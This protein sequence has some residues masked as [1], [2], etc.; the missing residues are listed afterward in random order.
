MAWNAEGGGEG[1][2]HAAEP[3][4][5]YRRVFTRNV[6]EAADAV[7]R[8]FC[9]HR[10]APAGTVESGF[11]ARH[12][13]AALDGFSI[14]YVAYGGTVTID[15]GCLDRFFLLQVPCAGEA[16]IATAARVVE[17][18]PGRTASLLSPTRPTRMEWRGDCAQIIVLVDRGRLEQ[19]AAALAGQPRQVVEFDPAVDLRGAW[20]Q[21]MLG[22][23]RLLVDALDRQPV[24][25]GL[26]RL[27]VADAR[28]ALLSMLLTGPRH[29]LS[30]AIHR[31][32]GGAEPTPVALRRARDH[33]RAHADQPFDLARLAGVAGFG[34]R[35]LQLGFK[36]HFGTTVSEMLLDIRLDHLNDRLSR[37]ADGASVTAIAY[38][39]GFNH[40]SRMAQ[41]YR[42]KFGEAPSTTL[43]RAVRPSLQSFEA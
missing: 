19:R 26:S 11:F 20:G 34:I 27:A 15:P 39:L 10:L 42:A 14:N 33:L 30:D 7:G 5:G 43:R 13:C 23:L 16:S 28:E 18:S 32:S 41:A 38:D 29:G 31:F 3:L 24:G 4:A 21:V 35:A 8:I 25:R 37:A 17:T 12:H 9:P 36:R 22:Q 6:D 1:R 2:W 40:L